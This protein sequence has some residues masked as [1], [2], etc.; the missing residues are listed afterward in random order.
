MVIRE[1]MDS[2]QK[3][4]VVV[5]TYNER[6][7][8]GKLAERVLTRYPTVELLFIDDNSP[9]GTGSLLDELAGRDSRV[10][11]LHRA[12]KLGLGTAYIMGFKWALE[13]DY[14]YVFEM[15]ADFSHDPSYIADFL[16]EIEHADLVLGSRYTNGVSVINWPLTRLLLSKFATLYVRIITGMPASDATGGFKCFR[17]RVLEMLDLDAIKSNGYSFQIE[18]TYYTW[19]AGF[20]IHEVP[21]IFYERAEGL[22]KMNRAIVREA[23]WVVWRLCFTH[24]FRR[25]PS[26]EPFYR[27]QPGAD[28]AYV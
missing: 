22:S 2:G 9:D 4:L 12:G 26:R 15:D 5:P 13:R 14:D 6:D 19:M 17:R 21:I 20:T 11:V 1:S 25:K 24:L 27:P 16:R 18:M 8:V 28:A 10:H 23:I 3:A 7:N